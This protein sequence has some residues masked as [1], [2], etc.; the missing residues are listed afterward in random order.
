MKFSSRYRHVS[1]GVATMALSVLMVACGSG[2]TNHDKPMSA[3]RQAINASCGRAQVLLNPVANMGQQIASGKLHGATAVSAVQN[4][5]KA[6]AALPQQSASS[7][8]A[9]DLSALTKSLSA[10]EADLAGGKDAKAHTV[11]VLSGTQR[12]IGLCTAARSG[13]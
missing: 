1:I 4:A 3:E 8:V 2:S 12:V 13:A 7:A 9:A 11:Q 5:E 6:L 10:L